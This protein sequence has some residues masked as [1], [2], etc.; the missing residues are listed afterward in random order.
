M[1]FERA[2]IK[3]LF[4]DYPIEEAVRALDV[5]K[6]RLRDVYTD[7]LPQ[8]VRWREQA[9][10]MTEADL[11]NELTSQDWMYPQGSSSSRIFALYRPFFVLQ[12]ISKRLLEEDE[13]N[14]K[15]LFYAETL[16]PLATAKIKLDSGDEKEVVLGDVV[17]QDDPRI[18]EEI[19]K[20]VK[21]L[22]N[23]DKVWWMLIEDYHHG[24]P[25]NDR[26]GINVNEYILD[27]FDKN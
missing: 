11:I 12:I 7:I 17:S 10:T 4:Y 5:S 13:T 6:E 19:N 23:K 21:L 18:Q 20:D 8:L 16:I 1:D 26:A 27:F 2:A 3:A 24:W 22:K 9:F 25:K 15:W 14:P